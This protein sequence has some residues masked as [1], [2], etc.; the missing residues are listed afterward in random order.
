M[1]ERIERAR[2]L[3]RGQTRAERILWSVLRGRRLAGFKF[4]RQMPIGPYFADF[5]CVE[6]RLIIELDGGQHAAQVASDAART[7][8][9]EACGYRVVRFWNGA[10]L[11]ERDGVIDAILRAL[12]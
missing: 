1:S 5:A 12:P 4:R 7:R 10:V 2:A 8:A 6:A 9:M 11:R 3:R